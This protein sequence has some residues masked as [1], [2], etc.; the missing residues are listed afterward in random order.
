MISRATYICHRCVFRRSLQS[1][2]QLR[3]QSTGPKFLA[4]GLLRRAQQLSNEHSEL[5]K[6]L[7]DNYDKKLATRAG[8]IS[9]FHSR[10]P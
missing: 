10:I 1:A 6:Q 2:L 9:K 8:R 7:A 4:D 5:E 3:V